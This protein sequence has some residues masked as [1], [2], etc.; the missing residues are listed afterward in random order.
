MAELFDLELHDAVND[1]T[2]A[3]SDDD[4]TIEVEEMKMSLFVRVDVV[5]S[6]PVS[7]GRTRSLRRVKCFCGV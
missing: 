4:D 7:R 5:N 2:Q 3:D 1:K 6:N